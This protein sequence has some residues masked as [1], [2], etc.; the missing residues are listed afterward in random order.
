[1]IQWSHWCL[2]SIYDSIWVIQH[3]VM[4]ETRVL[5]SFNNSPIWISSCRCLVGIS[6]RSCF[7]PD[8]RSVV[9]PLLHTGP[10]CGLKQASDPSIRLQIAQFPIYY[11]QYDDLE[12][13][14]HSQ[15]IPNTVSKIPRHGGFSKIRY[16]FGWWW[17]L[18]AK[19]WWMISIGPSI[20]PVDRITTPTSKLRWSPSQVLETCWPGARLHAKTMTG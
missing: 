6:D 14:Y 19:I 11:Q 18:I 20:Q 13:R 12:P 4:M 2:P 8:F 16:M 1:M 10:L 7:C 5:F 3:L 15:I 17:C 9:S